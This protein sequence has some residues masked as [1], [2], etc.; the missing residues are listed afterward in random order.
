MDTQEIK[1]A[2]SSFRVGMIKHERVGKLERF[3]F[4]PRSKETIAVFEVAEFCY[5]NSGEPYKANYTLAVG[6][7]RKD[8][9]KRLE[10]IPIGTFCVFGF[11]I[12]SYPK[13]G[14]SG[15]IGH[16]TKLKMKSLAM[17]EAKVDLVIFMQQANK[18]YSNL[19][20]H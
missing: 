17:I 14:G 11:Y 15:S 13:K 18:K 2:T 9:I 7:K 1:E 20:D 12:Q 6:T 19:L 8:F 10:S 5:D 16:V 4:E 3:Y